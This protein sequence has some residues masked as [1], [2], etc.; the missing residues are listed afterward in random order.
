MSQHHE[1]ANNINTNR[2]RDDNGVLSQKRG[3]TLVG[4]LERE[5]DVDSGARSNMRLDTLP[6]RTGLTAIDE[7]LRHARKR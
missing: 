5:Y 7:L 2:T 1:R 3:D 6:E 4:S